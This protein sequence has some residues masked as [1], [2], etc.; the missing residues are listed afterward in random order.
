[1]NA[2]GDAFGDDCDCSPNDALNQPASRA[3]DL[4]H[5]RATMLLSWDAGVTASAS[6]VHSGVI[7]ELWQDRGFARAI[8]LVQDLATPDYADAR[9]VPVFGEAGGAGYWYLARPSNVCGKADVG[10]DSS[11]TPRVIAVCP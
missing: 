6:D 7:S 11:G 1:M 9:A 5:A 4:R 2:D 10:T 8:C 3:T